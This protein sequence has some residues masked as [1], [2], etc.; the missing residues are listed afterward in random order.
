MSEWR[1]GFCLV[2]GILI[3]LY[4]KLSHYG[5]IFFDWKSNY[6]INVQIINTPNC[7]IIDYASGFWGTRHDIYRFASTKLGKNAS[8]YLE[9]DEW[10]WRDAGYFLQ[11][12]LII[13]YKSLAISLKPNWI[14]NFHLSRICIWS[15]YTISYLKSHFQCFKKLCF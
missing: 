9:K 8:Q 15:E 1:N 14:F 13:P 10:C 2:D 12:W 6:S 4:R 5:E 11:K 3:P 7:K